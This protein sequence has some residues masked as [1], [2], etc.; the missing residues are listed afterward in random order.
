MSSPFTQADVGDTVTVIAPRFRGVGAPDWTEPKGFVREPVTMVVTARKVTRL[1]HS[2]VEEIELTLQEERDE[3]NVYQYVQAEG[4]GQ[5]GPQGRL[6][7]GTDAGRAGTRPGP[8]E[9]VDGEPHPQPAPERPI[10]RRR[11]I[12][13]TYH[14]PWGPVRLS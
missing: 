10:A 3:H 8:S 5:G 14:T 13:F 6:P 9:G 12:N 4:Q 2:T 1:P 11:D 7:G